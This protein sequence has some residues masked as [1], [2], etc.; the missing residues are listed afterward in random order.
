[1]KLKTLS[2]IALLLNLLCCSCQAQSDYKYSIREKINDGLEVSSLSAQGIDSTPIMEVNDLILKKTFTKIHSLLIIKNGKLVFEE[3]YNGYD[4][5]KKHDLRSVTKSVVSALIGIAIDQKLV[6]V[7]TGGNYEKSLAYSPA[8][9]I[10]NNF[11]L[12]ATVK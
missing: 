11:I 12:T 6:A 9:Q 7:L 1:M 5:K 10:T 4:R 8:N 3:Y 2:I